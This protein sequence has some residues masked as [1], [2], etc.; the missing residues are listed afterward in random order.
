MFILLELKKQTTKQL[1]IINS[2]WEQNGPL[3]IV[4]Y[5]R[6]NNKST[7]ISNKTS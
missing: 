3:G 1:R 6:N 5:V 4:E 2:Y 7:A